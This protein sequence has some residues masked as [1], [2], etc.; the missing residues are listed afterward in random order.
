MTL[1]LLD[2][3][4][5]VLLPTLFTACTEQSRVVGLGIPS[6]YYRVHQLAAGFYLI[7]LL[8]VPRRVLKERYDE[9]Q[10]EDEFSTPT[11]LFDYDIDEG[12][13]QDA[14]SPAP[15]AANP[16]PPQPTKSLTLP[17]PPPPPPSTKQVPKGECLI[18]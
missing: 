6:I 4:R 15:A 5:P 10:E 2:W 1:S 11:S 18:D 3:T 16:E 17:L 14:V 9:G 13:D 7:K 12:V 8:A